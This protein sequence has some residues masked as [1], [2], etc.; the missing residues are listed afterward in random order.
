MKWVYEIKN[1]K[2]EHSISKG[3]SPTALCLK[4]NGRTEEQ[5]SIIE[6]FKQSI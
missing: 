5:I 3:K 6:H 4:N 2:F 1:R